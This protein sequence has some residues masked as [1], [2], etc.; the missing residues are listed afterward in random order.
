[1]TVNLDHRVL[2][3]NHINQRINLPSITSLGNANL[4]YLLSISS[5]VIE[6]KSS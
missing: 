2:F 6:S 1:M 3:L 4:A 5:A